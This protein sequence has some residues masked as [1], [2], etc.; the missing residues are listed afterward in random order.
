M[1]RSQK[2]EVLVVGAGP[3]G[4]FAALELTARNVAVE[5]V[6]QG[7]RSSQRSYALALHPATL[8]RLNELGLAE[9]LV[10]LGRKVNRIAF[11]EGSSRRCDV[12]LARLGGRFPFVLVLRQSDLERALED[13][14]GRRRV[15]VRWNHRLRSLRDEPDRA[16]AGISQLDQVATGYPVQTADWVE[17]RSFEREV[18]FVLGADGYDSVVRRM[19]GITS[20]DLGGRVVASVY[21]FEAKGELPDEVRVLVGPRS[22]AVY[23]PLEAGRCRFG[24]PIESP[25]D[26]DPGM[27]RL[28]AHLLAVAP[29]FEARPE[30]VYWS[31]VAVFDRS[32]A[33]RFG[34]GRCWI[35]GDAAHLAHPIGVHSMNVGMEEANALAVSFAEILRSGASLDRLDRF[36]EAARARWR[37][38]FGIE[39]AV[40]AL[41]AADPWVRDRRDR[42]LPCIPAS[43]SDLR[44]LLAQIGLQAP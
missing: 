43:G 37:F 3:V 15:E 16:V 12:D 34:R 2:P 36:D 20:A 5:I 25:S 6:D 17:V 21:E 28:R 27:D 11:Y 8:E 19:S 7:A 14:L 31:T 29:W 26:Y 9:R 40:A 1:A 41:P 44:E 32:L 4:L 10:R 38:L 42:I 24:F 18:S 35:A 30:A 33:E 39:P 22:T 13:E 23:W